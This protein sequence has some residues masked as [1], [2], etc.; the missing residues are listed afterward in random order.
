MIIDSHENNVALDIDCL[1]LVSLIHHSRSWLQASIPQEAL[2]SIWTQD[3][4][5]T[6]GVKLNASLSSEQLL[7]VSILSLFLKFVIMV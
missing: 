1:D 4:R 5:E 7:Q 2:Q 3:R 6:W